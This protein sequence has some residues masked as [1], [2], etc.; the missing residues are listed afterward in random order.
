MHEL[1]LREHNLKENYTPW[2]Q[3]QPRPVEE[4]ETTKILWNFAIQTD[5]QINHNRPDIVLIDKTTKDALLID[6]AIPS[7]YNISRKRL[8]KLRNYTDLAVEL[9]TIWNLNQVK[10]V[11]IIIGATGV[12]HKNLEGVL[13]S[14]F[15]QE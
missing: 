13:S 3:H 8:E 11:P 1:L 7:D 4:N 2:Y 10:I 12:I 14:L 6:V 15:Y 9:K 5:H